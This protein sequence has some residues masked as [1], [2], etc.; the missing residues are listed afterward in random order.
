MVENDFDTHIKKN[1][2][3]TK[4]SN[5]SYYTNECIFTDTFKFSDMEDLRLTK[6]SSHHTSSPYLLLKPKEK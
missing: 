1:R 2:K 6:R 5:K 3:E 4:Q